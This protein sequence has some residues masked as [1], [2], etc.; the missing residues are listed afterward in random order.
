MGNLPITNLDAYLRKHPEI[1]FVVFRDYFGVISHDQSLMDDDLDGGPRPVYTS[2]NVQPIHK[3][4]QDAVASFLTRYDSNTKG[5]TKQGR[6][7]ISAPYVAVYHQ[8]D[9]EDIM[10][11]FSARLTQGQRHQFQLLLD[12]I[13]SQ[14]SEEWN[15]VD[16]MI[17]Q[18]KITSQYI[19]YL[20]KPGDV[21]VLGKQQQTTGYTCTS[22]LRV[23]DTYSLGK[24]PSQKKTYCIDASHWTFDGVFTH[25]E[26]ELSLEIDTSDMLGTDITNLNVRP[27]RLLGPETEVTLRRRGEWFWRCRTRFLVSYHEDNGREFHHSGDDRYMVDLMMYRQLHKQERG[28]GEGHKFVAPFGVD[29]LGAEVM[30]HDEPP[31]QKLFPNFLLLM[32]PTIKGFNLKNKKWLDLLVDNIGE[33]VWNSEAF[34]NLVIDE[35][36][37]QLI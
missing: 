29:E 1:S 15:L 33:V 27:L 11:T 25:N 2:E 5:T 10:K 9:P 35:K 23:L 36:T 7:T 30:E 4:L 28:P 24:Q 17:A 22:W 19:G 20:L 3:D 26:A 37:K 12:Y 6:D 16:G 31:D 18:G 13:V 32:P 14:Y 21:V 8:R 34:R